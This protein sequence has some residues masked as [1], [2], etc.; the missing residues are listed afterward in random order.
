MSDLDDCFLDMLDAQDEVRGKAIKISINGVS[1]IRA[2]EYPIRANDIL[3]D[4][5]IAESGGFRHQFLQS[6]VAT[7]PATMQAIIAS[8]GTRL[9]IRSV[10]KINGIY[11]TEA[12]S[13]VASR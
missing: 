13:P 3:V 10:D 6:A 8:D 9:Q 2:F 5:A 12:F 7:V 4:G 1:G 11:Q